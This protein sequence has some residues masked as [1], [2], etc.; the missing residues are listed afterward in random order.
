MTRQI[1]QRLRPELEATVARLDGQLSGE[2]SPDAD[3]A[4]KRTLKNKALQLLSAAGDPE[5]HKDLLRRFRDASN[6]TDEVAAVSAL[7]DTEGESD[8]PRIHI[9][10]H[11]SLP[12]VLAV[13][14]LRIVMSYSPDFE[15]RGSP[16]DD[17]LLCS[18]CN[19]QDL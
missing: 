9:A 3:S 19:A 15:R 13:S 4:A 6:M 16:S 8:T 12:L 11:S 18:N 10:L 17:R 1:A 2:Y 5:V 14:F 7:A